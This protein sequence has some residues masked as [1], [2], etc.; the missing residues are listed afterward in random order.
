MSHFIKILNPRMTT[1]VLPVTV[2]SL[3]RVLYYQG[4]SEHASEY[5][6]AIKLDSIMKMIVF[7]LVICFHISI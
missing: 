4:G 6:F 7:N 3:K 2:Q 5:F 1:L